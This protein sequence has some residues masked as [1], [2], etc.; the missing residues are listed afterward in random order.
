MTV[1]NIVLDQFCLSFLEDANWR[2]STLS[3]VEVSQELHR[4]SV[5]NDPWY[6]VQFDFHTKTEEKYKD[7]CLKAHSSR[8]NSPFDLQLIIRQDSLF[9]RAERILVFGRNVS[10]SING[11]KFSPFVF[12]PAETPDKPWDKLKVASDFCFK[13]LE[14]IP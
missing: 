11:M 14:R 6:K 9:E 5:T 4:A 3:I 1:R 12:G 8:G 10:Q 13:L 7:F 2:A